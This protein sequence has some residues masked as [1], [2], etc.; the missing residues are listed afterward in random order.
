MHLFIFFL[1]VCVCVS[2]GLLH[3]S[4]YNNLY[5]KHFF[6]LLI[7]VCQFSNGYRERKCVTQNIDRIEK[8]NLNVG[9]VTQYWWINFCCTILA[10]SQWHVNV[11]SGQFNFL[12]FINF[13]CVC[14]KKSF[15]K[16]VQSSVTKV[17]MWSE[18]T[19]S[20]TCD[21]YQDCLM[22]IL[23]IEI[24]NKGAVTFMNHAAFES[25][26][27]NKFTLISGEITC[28][29]FSR[30]EGLWSKSSCERDQSMYFAPILCMQ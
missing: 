26:I 3:Q 24:L 15:G 22:N 5:G 7:F 20:T 21:G 10:Y 27:E 6:L 29:F 12:F 13:F 1:L 4:L 9:M 19:F 8:C 28:V 17:H 11:D 23:M 2:E 25:N 30:V 18:L 14:V 16:K